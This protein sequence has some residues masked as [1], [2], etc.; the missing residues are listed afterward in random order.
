MKRFCA[1]A[2][3]MLL[4]S[5]AHAGDSFSF[6]IGGRHVHI[7][8]SRHCNS[9]SCV[10]VSIPGIYEKRA[11]GNRHD[12]EVRDA[13]LPEP[14]AVPV[15]PPP[16]AAVACA[17]A[18]PPARPIVAQIAAAPQ[19]QIQPPPI[20]SVA[21]AAAPP[22]PAAPPVVASP[23]SPPPPPPVIV[24]PAQAALPPAPGIAPPPR[25]NKVVHRVEKEA[26][27]PLG[28]WVTEGNKGTV[29]IEPCGQALCGYVLD[30]ATETKGEAVL[31]DMKSKA[32]SEWTGNIYS[33]DSG[34]T[35]YAT[36]TLKDPNTIQ[37]EACALWRFWC[38]G[39]A[40]SRIPAPKRL[41]SSRF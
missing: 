13:P 3:L 4:G 1:L 24:R 6:V 33:R 15:A 8:R 31:I 2:V 23:P 29:R 26:D 22:P 5:S 12:E 9:A 37:V 25:V 39:N 10:S 20:Q 40:W 38:S 17:P 19:P 30:P 11:R 16:L 35:Y 21:I 7:D 41:L 32:R 28:D 14:V 18:A 34:D 36:L 27:G